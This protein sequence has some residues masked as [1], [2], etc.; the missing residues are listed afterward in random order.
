MAF[1]SPYAVEKLPVI[2]DGKEV[3]VPCDNVPTCLGFRISPVLP[4]G[5]IEV[6][7][8]GSQTLEYKTGLK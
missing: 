1:Y 7:E 8:F 6:T 4:E 2:I 3:V 5:L